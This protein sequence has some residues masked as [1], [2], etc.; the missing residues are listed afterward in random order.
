MTP[1]E[2]LEQKVEAL[3][4]PCEN[5]AHMKKAVLDLIHK[6]AEAQS[7]EKKKLA[8]RLR[9]IADLATSASEEEP[10]G[11]IIAHDLMEIIDE[12]EGK[13]PHI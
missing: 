2:S 13:E 9:E 12:L 11:D 8:G 10:L 6:N 4:T 7:E 1:S 5:A 3:P